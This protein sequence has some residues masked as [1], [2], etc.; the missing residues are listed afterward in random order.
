MRENAPCEAHGVL[1]KLISGESATTFVFLKPYTYS[2]EKQLL[3]FWLES[4]GKT[5][6][7]S[8]A[9]EIML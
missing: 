4:G 3:G 9:V 2:I 6:L 7:G 1:L 5:A 8:K